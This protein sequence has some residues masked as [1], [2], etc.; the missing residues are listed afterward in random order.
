MWQQ[1]AKDFLFGWS[2]TKLLVDF[3]V[4]KAK[5]TQSKTDI[6][7]YLEKKRVLKPSF[8]DRWKELLTTSYPLEL[9]PILI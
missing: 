7:Y 6:V 1:W 9:N 3:P 8:A 4:Q 5:L 2:L